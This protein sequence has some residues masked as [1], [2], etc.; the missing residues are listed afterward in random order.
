MKP[1]HIVLVFILVVTIVGLLRI[2]WQSPKDEHQS[3]EPAQPVPNFYD[4]E[5]FRKVIGPCDFA[6]PEDHAA[7]ETHKTEWW[8]YTGNLT[9]ADGHRFG[10]QLTFFRSRFVS[11]K[12]AAKWPE[13]RSAWRSPHIYLGHAAL[14]DLDG[15]T[16]RHEERTARGVLNVAGVSRE[17]E[18]VDIFLADWSMTVRAD[19]HRLSAHA[20]DFSLDLRLNPVKPPVPHGEDGYSRKGKRRESASCYYSFTRIATEGT[21]RSGDREYAVSGLSWMDREYSSAP[22]EEDLS[23]WD[24]FSLQLDDETELMLYYLRKKE[25]GFSSASGGTFVDAAG[26]KRDLSSE[27]ISLNVLE[28][29]ESPHSGAVYPIQWRISVEPLSLDLT[30]SANMADQEMRSPESTNVNYWEGSVSIDGKR[31]G[32]PV[33]GVGYVELT[34]YDK[35]FDAPM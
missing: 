15:E 14:S 26:N 21:V 7:H 31:R 24:W 13:A 23:G 9:A 19:G 27:N 17:G 18:T 20:E 32:K 10:Y 33:G 5:G 6:F 1:R 11:P 16:Y 3:E 34:G 4:A 2:D 8:Y 12:E 29:W 25:G 30:V 22:L 28:R 35:S